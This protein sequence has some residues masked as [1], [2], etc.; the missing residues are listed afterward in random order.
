MSERRCSVCQEALS[1]V[2]QG[3][4]FRCR[5]DFFPRDTF[6]RSRGWHIAC[7]RSGIALWK[8]GSVEVIEQEALHREGWDA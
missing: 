7:R 8:K 6:L 5:S 2:E 1:W 3:R 4:C